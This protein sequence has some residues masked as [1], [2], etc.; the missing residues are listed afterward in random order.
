MKYFDQ[1]KNKH[2]MPQ[3]AYL[4][5]QL[6]KTIMKSF[7]F[8]DNV[9]EDIKVSMDLQNKLNQYCEDI[10]LNKNDGLSIKFLTYFNLESNNKNMKT[11]YD[12]YREHFYFL[13]IDR[14]MFINIVNG[15]HILKLRESSKNITWESLE[16]IIEAENYNENVLNEKESKNLLQNIVNDYGLQSLNFS[17]GI[18]TKESLNKIEQ[19]LNQLSIVIGCDKKQVGANKFNLFFDNEDPTLAGYSTQCFNEQKLYLN[20]KK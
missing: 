13:G 14:N 16:S 3:N 10:I 1:L 18:T 5:Y 11:L 19:S 12:D 4:E 2:E 9:N 6:S 17:K 15:M 20:E 7:A 8:T